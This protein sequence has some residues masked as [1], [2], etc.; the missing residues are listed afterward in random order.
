MESYNGKGQAVIIISL[1]PANILVHVLAYSQS[2]NFTG[3]TR[4]PY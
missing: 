2:P 4:Q 1:L 3:Q